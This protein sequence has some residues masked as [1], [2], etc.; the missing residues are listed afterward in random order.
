[1]VV[2]QHQR[3]WERSRDTRPFSGSSLQVLFVFNT[4]GIFGVLYPNFNS[5][6]QSLTPPLRL[7]PRILLEFLVFYTQISTT[8]N[9]FAPPL[10][11][12]HRYQWNF[13]C[14]IPKFQRLLNTRA[15]S[16]S[17]TSYI[18]GVFGV[19]YPNL[20][21]FEQFRAFS[22]SSTSISVVLY[23]N[24]NDFENLSRLLFVFNIDIVGI[25]WCLGPKSQRLLNFSTPLILTRRTYLSDSPS[26]FFR[27]SYCIC[28]LDDLKPMLTI[29]SK[30]VLLLG[31]FFRTRCALSSNCLVALYVT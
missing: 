20:N 10:R 6:E 17:S 16:L 26:S 8:S 7:R 28:I 1:L 31:S 18:A 25:S 12:Q 13:W 3:S 2:H 21:D 9:S 27:V 4:V 22:S 5:F 19:L 23:S 11:L 14:F 29:H 15:S 30:S 24:F